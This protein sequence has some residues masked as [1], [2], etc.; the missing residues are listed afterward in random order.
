MRKSVALKLVSLDCGTEAPEEWAFSYANDEMEQE[1][2]AGSRE[3]CAAPFVL[4]LSLVVRLH[5]HSRR[6]LDNPATSVACRPGCCRRGPRVSRLSL[7]PYVHS[8]TFRKNSN[9]FPLEDH[10]FRLLGVGR[11]R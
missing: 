8:S 1:N 2:A 5:N 7:D 3:V 11:S 6:Y 9:Q 4:P 10:A